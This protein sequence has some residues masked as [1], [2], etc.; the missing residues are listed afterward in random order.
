MAAAVSQISPE[1]MLDLLSLTGLSLVPLG[2]L[3]TTPVNH[4]SLDEVVERM[5]DENIAS[6]VANNAR[7]GRHCHRTAR[8]G[9]PRH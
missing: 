6:F 9:L 3:G 2:A 8:P 5:S 4:P 7:R 1:L